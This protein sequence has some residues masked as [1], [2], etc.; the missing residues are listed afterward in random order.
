[1]APVAKRCVFW[2]DIHVTVCNDSENC[3]IPN[4]QPVKSDTSRILTWIDVIKKRR[5]KFRSAE[6]KQFPQ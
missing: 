5:R 3:E 1:M 4:L 6:F 2:K